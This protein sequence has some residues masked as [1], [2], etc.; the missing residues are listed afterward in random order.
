MQNIYK[1]KVNNYLPDNGLER[2]IV[3]EDKL[4]TASTV[5]WNEQSE[6][7]PETTELPRKRESLVVTAIN[8]SFSRI[9]YMSSGKP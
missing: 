7:K 9:L 1:V 3:G 4:T 8:R 5:L 6:W 2:L